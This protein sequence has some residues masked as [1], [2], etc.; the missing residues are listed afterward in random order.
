MLSVNSLREPQHSC[1]EEQHSE[2][3]KEEQ[4]ILWMLLSVKRNESCAP[5]LSL[6]AEH[7]CGWVI[8]IL[9]MTADKLCK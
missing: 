5:I 2:E 3:N 7:Q 8:N 9:D 1:Q 4:Q 6:H